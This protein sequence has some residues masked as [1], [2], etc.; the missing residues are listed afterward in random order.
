[1]RRVALAIALAFSCSLA[2]AQ[3][4]VL[5]HEL[6]GGALDAL[7]TLVLRFNDQQKGKAKVV[8]E[9]V[10]GVPDRHRVPHLALLD[11]E[12]SQRFFD[13]RPRFKPLSE[14]MKEGGGKLD[15]VRFYP[16]IA[17]A[18]DDIAGKLQG[19]PMALGLPVLYYNKDAFRK[20]GLDPEV[21]PKTWWEVQRMA[22]VLFDAGVKCPLTTSE[23][24]RV[25]LENVSTQHGEPMLAGSGKTERV[26]LNNMMHVKHVALLSSW[27]KS[28]YFHYFGPGREGDQK[29]L[30]GQCAM[31]TGESPLYA[32][33][34]KPLPFSVGVAPLPYYDDAYDKRPADVL[35][36]GAALVALPGKKKDEYKVM[37]RFVT[38]LLRPEV[39]QE[40]V[41]ATGFL[42]MTPVAV[43][44]L[45][46]AGVPPAILA[47]AEKRLSAKPREARTKFG[48]GRSKVRQILNEEIEFV[49]GNK[50][51]AKEALDTAMVRVNGAPEMSAR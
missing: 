29:F 44:A 14:M 6:S 41:R 39:Q 46:Q 43:D 8:L 31:L 17:D 13:T 27:Y 45:R 2:V 30:S 16:Q 15:G 7:S 28:F 47:A 3:E 25:H 18:V 33:L 10:S 38:F 35:P 49:W 26:T 36:D 12:D 34:P 40:W 11:P 42:P 32:E 9:E 1:M 4:I 19:L 51:P 24:T 37:A 22:G 21:P 48:F 50:K 20:A 23:F 5:R